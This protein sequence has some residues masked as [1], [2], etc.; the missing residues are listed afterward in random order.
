M[1]VA[2]RMDWMLGQVENHLEAHVSN[3]IGR[4]DSDK[5][6]VDTTTEPPY[7]M[8]EN[9]VRPI[10]I[11]QSL[12]HNER[13]DIREIESR[14]TYVV[15][16][17]FTDVSSLPSID[18]DSCCHFVDEILNT[19]LDYVDRD[20]RSRATY[21]VG[22]EQD[23]SLGERINIEEKPETPIEDIINEILENTESLV[24]EDN[25]RHDNGIKK[26]NSDSKEDTKEFDIDKFIE[27]FI[28]ESG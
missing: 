15:D 12:D 10:S 5:K 16:S 3:I 28:S 2:E 21:I 27:D 26:A 24:N 7:C 4:M 1:A 13:I 14:A 20:M 22:L 19:K 18:D 9:D 25:K 17:D 6:Q 23:G 11:D 8:K